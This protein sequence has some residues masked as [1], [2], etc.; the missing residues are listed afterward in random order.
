V[1]TYRCIRYVDILA[2]E[3]CVVT[4]RDIRDTSRGDSVLACRDI[5]EVEILDRGVL[6]IRHVEILAK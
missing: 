6:C 2:R 3:N 1:L 4:C 5:R